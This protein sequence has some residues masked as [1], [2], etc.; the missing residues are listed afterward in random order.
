LFIKYLIEGKGK[1]GWGRATENQVFLEG[2]IIMKGWRM[3]LIFLLLVYCAGFATAV[4]FLAPASQDKTC[5]AVATQ[6][7]FSP[8]PN[9]QAFIISFNAGMHKCVEFGKAAAL[10]T[11]DVIRDKIKEK[12]LKPKNNSS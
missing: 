12:Q 8:Q 1:T 11:A 2:R 9:S 4:Y 3:K 10:R 5:Q 6:N 7:P